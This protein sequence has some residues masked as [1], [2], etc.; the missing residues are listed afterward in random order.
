MLPFYD[1]ETQDF[2][3]EGLGLLWPN[4]LAFQFSPS[5][6][7]EKGASRVLSIK[8]KVVGPH[9]PLQNL[10]HGNGLMFHHC[11]LFVSIS[12]TSSTSLF[13]SGSLP[14]FL[15]QCLCTCCSCSLQ[16]ALPSTLFLVSYSAAQSLILNKDRIHP[17]LLRPIFPEDHIIA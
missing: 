7:T 17:A 11:P 9:H 5:V 1:E 12:G 10:A 8:T 3:L 15:P 4:S 14:H 6:G 16:G 13:F 2:R